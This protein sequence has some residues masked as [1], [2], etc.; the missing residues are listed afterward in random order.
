M[1]VENQARK[2]MWAVLTALAVAAV[3]AL[4]NWV[5]E[6]VKK[7]MELQAKVQALQAEVDRLPVW[8]IEKGTEHFFV[9]FSEDQTQTETELIPANEGVCYL[10]RTGGFRDVDD[11]VWILRRDDTWFLKARSKREKSRLRASVR[12]WRFPLEED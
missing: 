1:P 7:Y 4:G 3:V 11:A 2:T 10:T 9:D 6:E 8:T 5:S 12:C